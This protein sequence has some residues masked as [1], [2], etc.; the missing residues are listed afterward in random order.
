[1]IHARWDSL[2]I[3]LVGKLVGTFGEVLGLGDDRNTSTS[4]EPRR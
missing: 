1:M 3:F 4:L 2:G